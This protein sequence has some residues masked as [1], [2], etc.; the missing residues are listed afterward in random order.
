MKN[1]F[2]SII[3]CLSLI[4]T[5]GVSANAAAGKHLF[6]LSG[7]SNMRA[8][9]PVSFKRVVSGVFGE[10]NVIFAQYAR[11]SQPIR[12][13]YKDWVPPKGEKADDKKN[14]VFYDALM[15]GVDKAIAGKQIATVTFI[16][17]QG[18]ADAQRGWGAVY[19]KSFLG[20]L[21]QFK[22][23][24]GTDKINFVVGRINDRYLTRLGV[25]DGD[26]V[27]AVLK[28]LGDEH[29]EGALVN[30]DDLNTGVNPWGIYD[31][32]DGHFP[33]DAYDV[34]G[35]RFAVEACKL[36]DPKITID[37]SLLTSAQM[38]TPD[39]IKT[40]AAIGAPVSGEQAKG[41]ALPAVLTDGE[42]GGIDPNN[43]KWVACP[44]NTK[45]ASWVIDL[46]KEMDVRRVAASVLIN[47]DA[48][49][50]FPAT[51]DFAVSLD[52]VDYKTIVHRRR[53]NGVE[54]GYKDKARLDMNA[55][56]PAQSM[57]VLVAKDVKARY[58]KVT[59]STA[60]S[61]LYID[62]IAVNPIPGPS[63]STAMRE[64]KGF[65]Q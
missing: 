26:L 10:D 4:L 47:K 20:L 37:P 1:R 59:A 35:E 46:G 7:Q 6:I 14:G 55:A 58:V 63:A 33:N 21:D 43:G 53:S 62:E 17:M 60:E 34:L 28:K 16:W 19:E 36:I 9:L 38:D 11:P 42:F 13:W 57:L 39:D 23:D 32:A 49:A 29:A 8:G 64:G 15:R 31:L 25:K 52:G 40:H 30:T 22:K 48:S 3:I 50:G 44:P 12:Q 2:S 18:E 27:R 54:F 65:K 24:L 61:W 5:G 56:L 41:S 51:L 45:G